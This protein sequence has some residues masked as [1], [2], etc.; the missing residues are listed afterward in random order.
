MTEVTPAEVFDARYYATGCGRKYE[1]D[2][3]W[4]AFF[5][6]IADRI[7]ADI[8]PQSVLDAGC[9]LGFL[10]EGLRG[11]GVEAYGRDVSA[12]AID[13]VHPSIRPYCEKGSIAEPLPRRYD[14]IVSIEVLEHMRADEARA[15][16]ANLCLFTDDILFSSTPFDYK[17]VTHFN[18]QP[19]EYWAELFAQQG[20]YR[21]VDFDASFI[22]EWA[23]RLRRRQEPLH[24]IIRDYERGYWVL[25]KENRDLRALAL[26]LRQPSGGAVKSTPASSVRLN[27]R[28][29][30]E[31]AQA[32]SDVTGELTEQDQELRRWHQR[33]SELE[34]TPGYA[35]VRTLQRARNSIA[36]P[37][38]SR[39]QILDA[40]WQLIR[41]H[42]REALHVHGHRLRY[43]VDQQLGALWRKARWKTSTAKGASELVIHDVPAPPSIPP[44]AA[45]VDIVICVHNALDDVKLCLE[46]LQSYSSPPYRVIL[47][48]DGSDAP[49]ADYLTESA[50]TSGF[51][52]IRNEQ[53][54]GYTR[55]AN[56]GLQHSTADFVLLLNS[57]TVV[58]P[59]WLDRLVACMVSD[60]QIGIVGPLSNAA[61]WQSIPQVYD[62]ADWANNLLPEGLT[63]TAMAETVARYSARSYP[64]LPFLNGFCLLIRRQVIDNT[65]Y[66]DEECFGAG[67]GEENDYCLRARKSGWLLALA[68]DTYVY[69]A[70][71][72]S[73]SDEKRRALCD[74]ANETLKRK[75]GARSVQA[76]VDFLAG[77]RVLEG[78]RGHAAVLPQKEALLRQGRE[79]F[80]GRKVLWVLPVRTSGGGGAVIVS[81]AAIM[82]DMGVDVSIFNLAEYREDFERI[83]PGL[84]IP[85]FYGQPED[86]GRL[87]P[88]YDAVIAT[89]NVSAFWLLPLATQAPLTVLGYFIQD[90]EPYFYQ[91]T[92]AD[93]KLAWASYSVIPQMVR[94][95]TTEWIRNEVISNTGME[96]G[97]VGPCYNATLFRPA[98]TCPS[99]VA[100]SSSP[101][102]GND[103][104]D[105]AASC[106]QIDDGSVARGRAQIRRTRRNS[107]FRH[108]SAGARIP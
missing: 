67:Y 29:A 28:P 63:V 43:E 6:G 59:G 32:L 92:S 38:S 57:D 79:N 89:A 5:R 41:L 62:G 91:P 83:Y 4:L 66:L 103:S 35:F 97:L 106:A 73:Y 58:G 11:R 94:F 50:Q 55:A 68:D 19:P 104:S 98:T 108:E 86:V 105:D 65:G 18:V 100:G 85:V 30:D 95:A 102:C 56:Q 39:D 34:S 14:L 23:V 17:E 74:R 52:L 2:E 3:E 45:V 8:G 81:K 80:G 10:V 99:G 71:S 78:I 87:G 88:Q 44:H 15:A 25:R 90:F 107:P 13:N 72:K 36:P 31:L 12:F 26:E 22:T 40:A 75:H 33:W 20:F 84:D 54:R 53:P 7:I 64:R 9:A 21:D 61:T 49:T 42:N 70:G 76:G 96:C 82:R 77:D 51:L 27:E 37:R 16:I 93:Y 101:G 47:V 1:R 69:H 60:A 24:R 46:S 48:D